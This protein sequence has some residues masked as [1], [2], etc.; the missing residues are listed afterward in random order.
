MTELQFRPIHGSLDE[1]LDELMQ[2]GEVSSHPS[3]SYTIRLVSE[4]IIVNIIHYAYATEADA[5][6]ML[7]I[8]DEDGVLSIEFRDGGK[9]FNPLERKEPDVTLPPEERDIGGLGIFLVREMMD[10]VDYIYADKEN[11]LVIKKRY[12]ESLI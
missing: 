8:Q 10:E 4:E 2:S 9:P 3:L 5:Y 7:C 12:G 11:R 1:I 6:L